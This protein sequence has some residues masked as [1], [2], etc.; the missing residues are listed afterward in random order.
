MTQ[1]SRER[2]GRAA[3]HEA[4]VRAY[5]S[6]LAED[7]PKQKWLRMRMRARLSD[8]MARTVDGERASDEKTHIKST[9]V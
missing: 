3:A 1:R 4:A 9:A 8:T 6:W 7:E 5:A 2:M